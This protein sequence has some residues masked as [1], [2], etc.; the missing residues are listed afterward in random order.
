[1]KRRLALAGV[2][3]GL[4]LVAWA[5][6]SRPSDQELITARLRALEAAV[7]VDG[8]ENVVFR[9]SRLNQAFEEIFVQDVT[10]RIP[11]LTSLARGRGALAGVAAKSGTYFNSAQVTFTDLDIDV[12]PKRESAQVGAR[13]VLDAV[14]GDRR[15]RDDRRVSLRFTRP[16]GDW[17]IDAITVTPK[18]D[19]TE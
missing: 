19:E 13:V 14:E 6:L 12:D 4:G 15:R 10:V 5:V 1:M 16:D 11:E 2:A 7:A 9:T 18:S 17:L 8:Q 3:L